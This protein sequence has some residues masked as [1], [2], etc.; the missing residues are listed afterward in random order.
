LEV[1]RDWAL[2]ESRRLRRSLDYL[3][4]RHPEHRS[5]LA[6][7]YEEHRGAATE[8][9]V[10]LARATQAYYPPATAGSKANSLYPL[11]G[12]CSAPR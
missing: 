1:S 10:A 3:T 7:L 8:T 2:G 12:A 11:V 9:L 4:K 5:V 6:L